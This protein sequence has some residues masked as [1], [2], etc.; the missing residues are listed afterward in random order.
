MPFSPCLARGNRIANPVTLFAEVEIRVAAKTE[1]E[2]MRGSH[3][4]R[5]TS[6]ADAI[7]QQPR[8]GVGTNQRQAVGRYLPLMVL[9]QVQGIDPALVFGDISKVR[10]AIAVLAFRP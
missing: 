4:G 1:H 5:P 3:D 10:V 9:L 8:S 6:I 2:R 7:G